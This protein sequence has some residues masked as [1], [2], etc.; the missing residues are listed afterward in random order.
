MNDLLEQAIAVGQ[1][2]DKDQAYLLLA[3]L[4]KQQPD[5]AEAWYYLSTLVDSPEQ[6]LIFTR[7][8]L[9]IDQQH[10]LARQRLAALTGQ[11]LAGVPT[12]PSPTVSIEPAAS[13]VEPAAAGAPA[14]APPALSE[15]LTLP[16]ELGD[17]LLQDDDEMVPNWLMEDFDAIVT[18]AAD[19]TA[20]VPTVDIDPE[21]DDLPDWLQEEPEPAPQPVVTKA[22]APPVEQPAPKK[23]APGPARP[24]SPKKKKKQSP[25]WLLIGLA[26]AAVVVLILFLL[27][28]AALFL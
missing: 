27:A 9:A 10:S 24:G 16:A 1:A 11:P 28:V 25:N 2:G 23:T 13:V 8:T 17:L 5:N 20:V 14:I 22:V 4:I 12:P 21:M 6:Q 19:V 15:D 3:R 7:R 18:E 26:L